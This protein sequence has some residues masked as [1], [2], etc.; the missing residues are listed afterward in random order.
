MSNLGDK[1]GIVLYLPFSNFYFWYF[2]FVGAFFPY[3]GLYLDWL[4]FDALKI[5]V[6]LAIGP[7]SRVFAPYLFGSLADHFGFHKYFLLSFASLAIIFFSIIHSEPTFYSMIGV[8][9]GFGVFMSGILPLAEALTFKNLGERSILYGRI[10]LWGSVGFILTVVC[11][12]AFFENAGLSFFWITIIIF[13]LTL[14]VS[15]SLM[16]C[17]A[18]RPPTENL[19]S[20]LG[21]FKTPGVGLMFLAFFFMQISHGPFNGFFSLFLKDLGYSKVSIGL[22]WALGVV[23]EIVLFF[24]LPKVLKHYS[25]KQVLAFSAL[26]AWLRF[27]LI[28]WYPQNPLLLCFSQG[29]HAFTF[30]AFHAA[31]IAAVNKAFTDNS[32]VRG[33]ALYTSV[34]Y[35]AGGGAGV[36]LSG[37]CWSTFGGTWVF[38]G[39]AVFALLAFFL[40]CSVPKVLD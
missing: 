18:D 4:G 19:I 27:L 22:F 16:P 40:V 21:V 37:I 32:A 7:L 29:L 34:S 15:I 20:V 30:G 35:G 3:F 12:G 2:A 26:L 23:A 10:R 8:L 36:L 17:T 11:T 31:G 25:L 14:I 6:L 38:T 5:S 28:A 24:Y 33:Q 13:L 1:G 9:A 39:G